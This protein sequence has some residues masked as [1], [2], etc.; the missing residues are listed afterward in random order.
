MN[1]KIRQGLGLLAVAAL[2][3]LIFLP[4]QQATNDAAAV[5]GLIAAITALVCGVVGLILLATGLLAPQ[6]N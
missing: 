5:V 4:A 3:F 1:A 2:A 6:K